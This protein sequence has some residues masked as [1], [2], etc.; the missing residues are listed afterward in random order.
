MRA[1][2]FW[3]VGLLIF[4]SMLPVKAQTDNTPQ[5]QQSLTMRG[6]VKSLTIEQQRSSHYIVVELRCE[7]TNTGS[8]PLIF[9][10][11]KYEDGLGGLWNEPYVFSGKKVSRTP[12]FTP[13]DILYSQIGGPSVY[14]SPEW[15]KMHKALDQKTPPADVTTILMPNQSFSFDSK[16]TIVCNEDRFDSIPAFSELQEASVFWLRVYYEVWSFNLE[17]NPRRGLSLKFGRKLQRKWKDVGKLW[18]DDI[19][20]EPIQLDLKAATY[21]TSDK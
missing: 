4:S 9:W 21:K 5:S 2:L 7:L 18:L 8:I 3:L 10:K 11:Y 1:G 20:T 17:P 13:Q 6:V 12:N 14:T 16:V 19:Y 15:N